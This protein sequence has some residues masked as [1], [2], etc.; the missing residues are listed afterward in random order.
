[1]FFSADSNTDSLALWVYYSY[2][3]SR[4]F[5]LRIGIHE[6]RLQT[7][8]NKYRQDMPKLSAL[9]QRSWLPEDMK[10]YYLAMYAERLKMLNTSI[11]GPLA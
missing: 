2:D 1:M 8:L 6:N 11:G 3:D 9:S 4:D 5:G 10:A 7:L